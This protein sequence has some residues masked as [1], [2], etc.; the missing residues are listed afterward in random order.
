MQRRL[1]STRLWCSMF[2]VLLFLL[3]ACGGD[4]SQKKSEGAPGGGGEVKAVEDTVRQSIEAEDAKDAGKF[5][6]LWTDKGLED[7]DSGTREEIEK[8]D[9]DLGS[10]PVELIGLSNTKVDG[11]KATTTA[12]ATPRTFQVA[13]VLYQADF[14]LIKKDGKWL[15]DGFNFVGSPPAE[16]GTPV[17]GIKAVEYGFTLDKAEFGGNTAFKFTNGGKQQHE[18]TLFKGPDGV[19]IGTAKTALENVDGGELNNVPAGYK[20]DHVSFT[21]PGDSVDVAFAEPLAAGT[22]I[23]ACYIPDGGFGENGPVNPEG[24]PHIQLGMINKFTVT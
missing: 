8:G 11:D 1:G 2:V 22:Y 15:I 13:K 24:K 12:R 23:I 20:V 4:S 18:L 7:F 9:S 10:D 6:A 5:L 3:G 19:D 21:E 16:S 14:S 17:V